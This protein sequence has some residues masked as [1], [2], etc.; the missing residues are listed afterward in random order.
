M[1][2]KEQGET[3]A[4][5][6][7]DGGELLTA[8]PDYSKL[9]E[10]WLDFTRKHSR[11]KSAA[12]ERAYKNAIKQALDWFKANG[13][14]VLFATDDDIIRWRDE[15]KKSKSDSTVQL[16][17]AALKMFFSWL[18]T[19][20]FISENPTEGM[21]AGVTIDRDMHKRDYLTQDKARELIAAMPTDTLMNLRDR[22]VVA[23]MITT[24][25][26]CC[27]VQ[28]A[29]YG[30]FR[31]VGDCDVLYIKGKGHTSNDSYVKVAPAVG[32]M[33]R[34]YLQARF[35]AKTIQNKEYLF[36]STRSRET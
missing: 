27:E 16:Y 5:V 11:I 35:G 4:L 14:D 2:T 1:M 24:G 8:K 10:S 32:K 19:A 9:A 25:L 31:E 29:K 21:T 17:F 3:K 30:D 36:V 20:G 7:I 28:K 18:K 15:M 12:S 26:R 34:E 33:I 13:V 6:T 23:L 22:A